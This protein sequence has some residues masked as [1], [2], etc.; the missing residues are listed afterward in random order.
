MSVSSPCQIRTG[1]DEIKLHEQLW[2]RLSNLYHCQD[3]NSFFF[4]TKKKWDS[5]R[6]IP[7]DYVEIRIKR[8]RIPISSLQHNISRSWC[9]DLEYASPL[10]FGLMILYFP[11]WPIA[12]AYNKSLAIITRYLAP[13]IQLFL[14]SLCFAIKQE[15]NFYKFFVMNKAQI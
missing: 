8:H 12:S 5:V 10:L 9:Q 1:M 2:T 4:I 6:N 11:S 15:L 7:K 14:Q 3:H 13:G